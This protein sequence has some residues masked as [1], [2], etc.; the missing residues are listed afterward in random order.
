MD[1]TGIPH[2]PGRL[3]VIGDLIGANPRTPLQ[4]TLRIGKRL[5][6]IFTRKIFGIEIVFAG[7]V[8]LVTQLNDETKFGKHVGLGVEGLRAVAGDGL[9]T[10]HTNEP[11]W[12]LAHDILQPAFSAD[13][14]RRYHPVMLEVAHE[15]TEAW[16]RAAGPVDVAADMTRLTL[17]TI[18]RAGFGYRFGSFE[19]AEPHPFVTAMIRALRFAQLQNVKLPFVRRT[20]AGSPAQN[21]ADIATMTNL[22]DEVIEARRREGGE[23]RDLL[24]LMLT[25]GHPMTGERLDPV[26]IRNQAITFVVAG[27]ETT[28]G[29]L[30][31]ALYYLTRHP[32]LL[33]KAR[34]EVDA[35]WGER[36]PEFGDVARLRYMRRVLDE[37]MR[38]WPTAPGYAREA[39]EDVVLGGKYPM[40]KGDWV[41]VPLPLVHR[42][43]AVWT[44]P[45]T[46]DPDRFEP[47]AVRKRPAQAYKPFGT[48]ERACIGR[49]FALHEAVLALGL[50]LRRY[51]FEAD[52]GYELKIVESLTLKP[53]GFTVHPR[54]RDHAA[55]TAAAT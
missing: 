35:V 37:A 50:V 52:P 45:E 8:D 25:E 7:G 47:A 5:G 14:M 11:N 33:A 44:D 2:R 24:G 53:S 23:S 43:P 49:Q 28:S 55:T 1:T 31:F 15:L 22:V 6:P 19:R 13:A 54:V 38:L 17:E 26:N 27:H 30:S 41:I 34:A 18:G 46:F 39:R 51:D 4:H 42:D 40:R 9:F 16:D 3:P 21:R 32:E 36:E 29:A 12:R 48:G 10:A 20:F